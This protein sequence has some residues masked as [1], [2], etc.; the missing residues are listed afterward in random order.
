MNIF[1]KVGSKCLPYVLLSH[2]IIHDS[3]CQTQNTAM[4]HRGGLAAPIP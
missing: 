2:A 3:L 1:L 4:D